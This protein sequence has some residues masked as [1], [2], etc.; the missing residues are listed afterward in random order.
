[1]VYPKEQFFGVFLCPKGGDLMPYKPRRPCAYPGCSRLATSEQYC[2]EHKKLVNKHYNQYDVTLIQQTIRSGLKRIR[3]RH[4][5]AHPLCEECEK[6]GMLTPAEE[7]HHIFPSQ[8][9]VVTTK[10]T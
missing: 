3:D 7:V 8:K 5:K 9:V 6:E 4:I 10:I 2:A 1:M